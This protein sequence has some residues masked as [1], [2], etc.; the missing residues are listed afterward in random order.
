MLVVTKGDGYIPIPS[1]LRIINTTCQ[2][3]HAGISYKID[4]KL[5]KIIGGGM[6]R[7]ISL[8]RLQHL[9]KNRS[10]FVSHLQRYSMN[11]LKTICL[12]LKK[13]ILILLRM[14]E[15]RC[16]YCPRPSPKLCTLVQPF[17]LSLSVN[18]TRMLCY[19]QSQPAWQSYGLPPHRARHLGHKVP[20]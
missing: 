13:K 18:E 20:L 19:A 3:P 5:Q 2:T 6:I 16:F 15:G 10:I 17:D 1:S 8:T 12:S 11:A 7:S 4:T 9:D 14:E